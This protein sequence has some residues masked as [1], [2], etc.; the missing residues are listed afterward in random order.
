MLITPTRAFSLS[1]GTLSDVFALQKILNGAYPLIDPG[2][3]LPEVERA[4]TRAGVSRPRS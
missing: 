4:I 1:V 2:G 3:D